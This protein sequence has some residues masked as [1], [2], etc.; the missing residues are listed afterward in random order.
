MVF[1][2]P[3]IRIWE[4]FSGPQI[5]KCWSILLSIWNILWTFGIFYDH[6][7]H[8]VLIWYIFFQFW[9]H[10]P[11]KIWQPW[12]EFRETD[13]GSTLSETIFC[14]NLTLSF[15][16]RQKTSHFDYPAVS[17]LNHSEIKLFF[18]MLNQPRRKSNHRNLLKVPFSF[19]AVLIRLCMYI[20]QIGIMK[21]IFLITL[22]RL[23]AKTAEIS[24]GQWLK[25][26]YFCINWITT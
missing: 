2:K 18:L 3:K 9:Y 10:A 5:R 23:S 20:M 12:S 7:V 16:S 17:S 22:K 19:G 13:R 6:S 8:F 1:F 15:L 11:R 25:Y 24:S 26:C 14:R 21:K 4:N